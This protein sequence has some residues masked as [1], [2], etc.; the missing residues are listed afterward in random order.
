MTHLAGALTSSRCLVPACTAYATVHSGHP[1]ESELFEHQK[2]RIAVQ[3]HDAEQRWTV[4]TSLIDTNVLSAAEAI[5]LA[6]DMHY[7]AA[8]AA[9]LNKHIQEDR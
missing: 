1:H 4:Q 9:R 7:A 8:E 3:K 6:N 2:W 5:G